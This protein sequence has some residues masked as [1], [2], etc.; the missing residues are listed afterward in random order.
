[1]FIPLQ[2]CEWN[3]PHRQPLGLT[4]PQH[5][6]PTS[7]QWIANHLPLP[8]PA[9]E[10]WPIAANASACQAIHH[11]STDVFWPGHNNQR[12]WSQW[13]DYTMYADLSAHLS[14]MLRS[15]WRSPNLPWWWLL[16]RSVCHQLCGCIEAGLCEGVHWAELGDQ[17][18]HSIW[19]WQTHGIQRGTEW[20]AW[21]QVPGHHDGVHRQHIHSPY[22]A[23]WN[24]HTLDKWPGNLPAPDWT[25]FTKI[26]PIKL[27][28]IHQCSIIINDLKEDNAMLC[29]CEKMWDTVQI[30][31]GQA[32]CQDFCIH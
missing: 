17:S 27:Q 31:V 8:P 19:S 3:P 15:S 5:L 25:T 9:D 10:P 28:H 24:L 7:Q 23:L 16:W 30:N 12:T 18:Q 26:L 4:C 22:H 11:T 21:L 6:Q 14:A 20:L 1:M 29:W 13:W 32:F 2:T